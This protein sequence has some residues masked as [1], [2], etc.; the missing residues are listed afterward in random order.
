PVTAAPVVARKVLRF[1][2]ACLCGFSRSR[3]GWRRA[4]H[5][6]TQAADCVVPEKSRLSRTLV[7]GF[8]RHFEDLVLGGLSVAVW[9]VRLDFGPLAA[10][11]HK[12]QE[13]Q[14]SGIVVHVWFSP[15]GTPL[16]IHPL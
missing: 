9:E 2:I 13:S 11:M 15:I 3:Q 7:R 4:P 8:S 1:I 5:T 6:G 16:G 14:C 10:I 12:T